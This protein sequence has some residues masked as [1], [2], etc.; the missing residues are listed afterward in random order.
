[1]GDLVA[2]TM[3]DFGNLSAPTLF[4]HLTRDSIRDEIARNFGAFERV[5]IDVDG[6][7]HEYDADMIISALENYGRISELEDLVR[8]MRMHLGN[9]LFAGCIPVL[10]ALDERMDALGLERKG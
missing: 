6:E 9:A 5:V 8:D 2:R 7:R 3:G 10:K 4:I 1:M